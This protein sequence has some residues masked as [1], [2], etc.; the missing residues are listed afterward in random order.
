M[1]STERSSD[2][3][4]YTSRPSLVGGGI[5]TLVFLLTLFGIGRVGDSEA[6]RL[7]EATLPTI[8]FLCSS[9]IAGAST[10]L[11]LM[12]TML[13][14]SREV[15]ADLDAEYYDRV[16]HIAT[17]C[18]AVLVGA[19]GLLLFLAVPLGESDG[20]HTWYNVIYYAVLVMS[21][22]LGGS[23]VAIVLSIRQAVLTLVRI[24]DPHAD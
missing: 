14:L 17:L 7:L 2:Y 22:L 3:S 5:A 18:V 9:S 23:L 1:S 6:I 20:L 24:S 4:A 11:A 13:G 21:S 12:L 19:V 15:D 16:R 8:R 10:V